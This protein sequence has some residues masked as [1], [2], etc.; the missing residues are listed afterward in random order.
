MGG[1]YVGSASERVSCTLLCVVGGGVD[2]TSSCG[3]AG[4]TF[5]ALWVLWGPASGGAALVDASF[6]VDA[7]DEGEGVRHAESKGSKL[8][9]ATTTARN[10]GRE[11]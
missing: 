9:V 4:R 5:S 2:R 3:S 8:A 1:R 11:R 6:V 7:A 10:F